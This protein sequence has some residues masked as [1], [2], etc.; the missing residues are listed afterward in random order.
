[1]RLP[2]VVRG[3]ALAL[4]ALVA[5]LFLLWP[6]LRGDARQ[7]Q[8]EAH[9]R[10]AAAASPTARGPNSGGA[11]AAPPKFEQPLPLY[12]HRGDRARDFRNDAWYAERLLFTE[13]K[14]P[15]PK[16]LDELKKLP[17]FRQ[18]HLAQMDEEEVAFDLKLLSDLDTCFEAAKIP[19]GSAVVAFFFDFENGER[20]KPKEPVIEA[21]A[22]EPHAMPAFKTCLEQA[23]TGGGF[24]LK[25]EPGVH[26]H[27]WPTTITVPIRN[28][29][30]LN[31]LVPDPVD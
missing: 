1:M 27:V 18:D 31:Y 10:T 20:V 2:S 13:R 24:A 30:L 28:H 19:P 3:L 21:S 4:V 8:S 14:G 11:V 25:Q 9:S 22:I 23:F 5:L 6:R 15:V 29:D 12:Y 26:A 16:G 17:N 7:T